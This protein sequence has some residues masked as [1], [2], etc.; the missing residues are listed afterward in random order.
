MIA[1]PEDIVLIEEKIGEK[2]WMFYQANSEHWRWKKLSL[3][4]QVLSQSELAFN[5]YWDCVQDARISGYSGAA[6]QAAQS[7]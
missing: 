2:I 4:R 7:G 6:D 1:K 3:N 5:Q